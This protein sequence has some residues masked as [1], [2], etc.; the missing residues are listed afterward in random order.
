MNTIEI[1]LSKEKAM[2]KAKGIISTFEIFMLRK[3]TP[4]TPDE[5]ALLST[6]IVS[7]LQKYNFALTE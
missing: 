6:E 1:N 4:L 3:G 2:N 5:K 7:Q